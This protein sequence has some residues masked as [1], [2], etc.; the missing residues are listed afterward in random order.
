MLKAVIFDLDDTLIDWELAEAWEP[1]ERKRFETLFNF[2]N[3]QIHPLIGI[4]SMEL[5]AAFSTAMMR[6]WESSRKT[7]NAPSLIQIL[8]ETLQSLGIPEDRLDMDAVMAVYDWQCPPGLRAFPDTLEVLPELQAHGVQLGI[9]TNSSHPMHYRDRELNTVGLLGMF[10]NCRLSAVDVGVLKPH[11]Q[12]FERALKILDVDADEAVFVG[13]NLHADVQGAQEAGMY[14]VL[15]V[16]RR[17]DMPETD[18]ITPDG[19]ITTL[20]ELLPL[21]DDWYPGWR[22]NGKAR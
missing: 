13:D 8:K 9:I 22:N 11:R 19:T 18:D 1:R 5:F 20:H 17:E 15:R 14:G 3:H 16:R 21:L 2:I 7:L 4:E 12:I 6:A 10:P